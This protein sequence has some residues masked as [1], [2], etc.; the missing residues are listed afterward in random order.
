MVAM[1]ALRVLRALERRV[2][3]LNLTVQDALDRLAAVRLVS[4]ADPALGLWRLPA[5]FHEPVQKVLAVMPA[6]PVPMLSRQ[7]MA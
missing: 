6:L 1:L 7:V 4:L 2:A 5:R 3:P